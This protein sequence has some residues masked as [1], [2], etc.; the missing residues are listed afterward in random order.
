MSGRNAPEVSDDDCRYLHDT[1]ILAALRD[2]QELVARRVLL[3]SEAGGAE[4]QLCAAW[5]GVR[6]RKTLLKR[7]LVP[8]VFIGLE[9][10]LTIKLLPPPLQPPEAGRCGE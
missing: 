3:K 10:D 8:L 7:E 4:Q 1:S 6:K 9:A 2:I 5:R